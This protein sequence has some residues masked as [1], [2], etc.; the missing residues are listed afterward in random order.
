MTNCQVNVVAIPSG[1]YN[2]IWSIAEMGN[3]QHLSKL[4][5]ASS[6]PVHIGKDKCTS[7]QQDAKKHK[8][9]YFA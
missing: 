4:V 2:D 9:V 1:N 6:I 8:R 7:W 3:Y 5:C